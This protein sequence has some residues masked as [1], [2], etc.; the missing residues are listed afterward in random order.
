MC[1][2]D[3]EVGTDAYPQPDSQKEIYSL[4]AHLPVRYSFKNMRKFFK[5]RGFSWIPTYS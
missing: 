5:I 3:N 4:P 2:D 1:R